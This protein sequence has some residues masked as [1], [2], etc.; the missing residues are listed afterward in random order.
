M[1]IEQQIKL[2]KKINSA[3]C[4][5]Y[6]IKSSQLKNHPEATAELLKEYNNAIIKTLRA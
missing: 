2:M 3:Y 5:K 4:E 1:T 6:K